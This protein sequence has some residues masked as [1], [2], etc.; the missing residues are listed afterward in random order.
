MGGLMI[1]K[2]TTDLISDIRKIKESGV[3]ENYIEYIVFPFYKNL[4]KG[5]RINFEFPLTV[6]VGRNGSGKSSTLHALF[7]APKGYSLGDFWFSTEVDPI[8]ESG[9]ANR[10][11]Y[12]Y[13]IS[14]SDNEIR[15]V[16]KSRIKRSEGEKKK[17]IQI[18]G[19]LL[20]LERVMV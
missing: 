17:K 13:R 5:T 11:Y 16:M 2:T 15:E 18:I 14:K 4:N 6:L 20:D 7:G 19:K 3:F 12:G 1:M 8:A 9:E 10:F